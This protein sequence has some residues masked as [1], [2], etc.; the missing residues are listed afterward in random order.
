[1]Y[2]SFKLYSMF[3]EIWNMRARLNQLL[4]SYNDFVKVSPLLSRFPNQIIVTS[5]FAKLEAL[6]KKEN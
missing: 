2:F 6:A 5:E 4:L 3:Q 1:M